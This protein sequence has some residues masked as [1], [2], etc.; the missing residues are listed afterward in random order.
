MKIAILTLLTFGI[1]SFHNSRD[2]KTV[3]KE[4]S[5]DR[6]VQ[7][8]SFPM[9]NIE[10]NDQDLYK[11]INPTGTYKL[12]NK[13]EEINGEI[14]GYT[15]SIKVKKLTNEKIVMVFEVNK[16]APSYNSGSFVDT[17]AYKN[18]RSIYTV[19]P[20]MDSTC[21]ITFHFDKK[22]VTVVEETADYNSGCG[23]GHAVVADG[24]YKRTS[25]KTPIL[26]E[27]LTDEELE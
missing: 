6:L 1:I 12:D 9:D 25:R 21:K 13:I 2:R 27:P 23:F 7:E 16:G 15:G 18:N 19:P 10:H 22:G 26:K 5:R 3:Q 4:I 14:Y 11:S 24:F 20:D 8:D 17:L